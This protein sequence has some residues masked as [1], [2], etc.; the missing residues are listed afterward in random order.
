MK[1]KTYKKIIAL[2][3]IFASALLIFSCQKQ[4]TVD[5]DSMGKASTPTEAYTMLYN[6]VKS[7]NTE[8][9][10][11]V[12]SEKSLQFAENVA[13]QRNKPVAEIL[14]NGLYASTINP[15][16]PEVR[17]E[18]IKDDKFGAVEVFVK[19]TNNYEQA[20]FIKENGGWKVAVGDLF[21]GTFQHPEKSQ[22]QKEADASNTMIPYNP[23]VNGNF[24]SGKL[25]ANN[26]AGA[27]A[28]VK[29]IEVEPA[30]KMPKAEEK[31]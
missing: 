18:R 17:D 29:T 25:D 10:K 15:E 21:A 23:N 22:A 31:K 1:L 16:M 11:Q 5:G 20:Y 14:E 19:K 13:A 27:N 6:A 8:A 12:M 7:K 30:N 2:T 28:K 4:G 3:F 9:I 26:P 24:R